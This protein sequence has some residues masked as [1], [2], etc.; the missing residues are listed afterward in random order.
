MAARPIRRRQMLIGMAGAATSLLTM[1]G[2]PDG[3]M[4]AAAVPP[5]VPPLLRMLAFVPNVQDATGG[6]LAFLDQWHGSLTFANVGAVKWLYGLEAVRSADDIHDDDTRTYINATSGCYITEFTGRNYA[7]SGVYRDAFGYDVF[8]VDREISAGQPPQYFS[9][10]EGTFHTD[11]VVAKLRDGGYQPAMHDDIPYFTIRDDYQIAI[12][13]PRSRLALSRMNRVAVDVDRIVA[14]GGTEVME[15]LLDAEA[16]QTST[17][18][19][20]PTLRALAVALGDVTSIATMPGPA[21]DPAAVILNPD[22]YADLTRDWG[23]LHPPELAAMGYTDMGN[24]QRTIHVALVYTNPDDA[25]ADAPELVKRIA[26]YRL[27][28]TQQPFIPTDATGVTSRVVTESGKGVLIADITQTNDPARG[29]LWL[30][31][32][33]SRDF[34]FLDPQPLKP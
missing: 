23:T 8:Q 30:Q 15:A 25:A 13:D 22:Q 31:M 29:G 4:T 14:T 21:S 16:H 28:R 20:C 2:I 32:Y 5:F 9:R 33:V 6:L 11:T 18:A 34:L 10:M 7:A 17:L 27:Q 12:T 26:G 24:F 3:S 19:D 1:R